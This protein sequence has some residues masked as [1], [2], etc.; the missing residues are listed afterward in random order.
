MAQP[1]WSRLMYFS[2]YNRVST[3][4]RGVSELGSKLTLAVYETVVE[5]A[6]FA[7]WGELRLGRFVRVYGQ[8]NRQKPCCGERDERES[9]GE[10]VV[11][12][13]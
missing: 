11:F 13:R 6:I 9:V 7:V 10:A 1:F 8:V 4:P 5:V 12:E 2:S 3:V